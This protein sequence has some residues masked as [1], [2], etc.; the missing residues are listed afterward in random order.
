MRRG[1]ALL[2]RRAIADD[3]LAGDQARSVAAAGGFDGGDDLLRVM[4]VDAVDVPAGGGEPGGLIRR[5]RQRGGAVDGDGIVVEQHDQLGQP[6]MPGEVDGFMADAF[7]QAAVAG[8]DIG[9]VVHQRVAEAGI[10]HPLGQRHADRVRQALAERAGGG[11]DAR[12]MAIFRMAGR[13][14]SRAGGNSSAPRASCPDSRSGRAANRAASS[15]DRRRA[16]SGR[17]PASRGAAGSNFRKRVNST[18]ATS[19][20]PIGMP[21]W[22][23]FAASTASIDSARMALARSRS[24]TA[25][26]GVWVCWTVTAVSDECR[27]RLPRRSW[28]RRQAGVNQPRPWTEPPPESS[29]Q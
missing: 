16:R 8:D 24:G 11:L 5:R 12:R 14:A 4:P 20:M 18:V 9:V 7:H 17:G 22:P 25:A 10:Q 6:Q 29:L 27:L 15:R 23:E 28:R 1:R 19:A 2:G 13:A 21:G 26:K 3:R